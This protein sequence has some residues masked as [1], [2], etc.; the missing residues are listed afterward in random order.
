MIP[1]FSGLNWFFAT[2][3]SSTKLSQRHSDLTPGPFHKTKR[4]TATRRGI[5]RAF[6]AL[7]I[8]CNFCPPRPIVAAG[9][10]FARAAARQPGGTPPPSRF[11]R[12]RDCGVKFLRRGYS[13]II[14]TH[15]SGASPPRVYRDTRSSR[16]VRLCSAALSLAPAPF[17]PDKLPELRRQLC[18]RAF[19]NARAPFFFN[20]PFRSPRG[21]VKRFEIDFSL[22]L[23]S[24]ALFASFFCGD[25]RFFRVSV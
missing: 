20:R 7:L 11:A 18:E 6:L 5:F 10:S 17:S 1:S 22:L 3:N 8:F 21:C 16:R 15:G 25:D 12:A 2:L 13:R 24:R 23:S 19:N 9:L 14:M 4:H